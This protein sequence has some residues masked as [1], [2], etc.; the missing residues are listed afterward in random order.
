M[1]IVF[2]VSYYY[3]NY[4]AVGKCVGNV[5]DELSK[6]HRVTVIC[7]KDSYDQLDEE[8]INNQKIIRFITLDRK[9]RAKLNKKI[10]AS[11]GIK[12]KIYK[13]ILYFYKFSQAAKI[14]LSKVTI[15]QDLVDEYFE[16]L[17]Y[18]EE[19][20][21]VIIPAV[22][23]F[24]SLLAAV[25]FSKNIS[26]TVKV[27]PYL[28][29]Q[30]ALNKSL[31][32]FQLNMKLKLKNHLELERKALNFS[33]TV[34]I[35]PQ[36]ED[37]YRSV[38]QDHRKKILVLEH[39]LL[40]N[41]SGNLQ[42]DSEIIRFVYAG[43]F[44]KKIRNPEYFLTVFDNLL[45][46]IR[47]KLDLYTFGNCEGIIDKFSKKNNFII[48]HGK[49]KTDKVYR[50]LEKSNFLVAVGNSISN[51]VPSKIIE[52]LSFGKPIIYLYTNNKDPGLKYLKKFPLS[53]CLKQDEKFLSENILKIKDF[54][55]N[56]YGSKVD[57]KEVE[58]MFIEASPK[59]TVNM[60]MKLIK[61]GGNN[62]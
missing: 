58:R 32:R 19:E 36:L 16:A 17:D 29:D 59:Y 43:S 37:H 60:I 28:F 31:H 33:E 48:S 56:K 53:L 52:Y 21:D 54:C 10:K 3:P 55:R 23:P 14:I 38:I 47:G 41:K 24:E 15:K 7:E 39:P 2:L 13:T 6:I 27:I 11:K 25:R 30:F 8:I 45:T 44:Y 46:E 20:I 34:I 50:A 35:M 61:N 22:M 57:F 12:R 62:N 26:S 5:A 51:Q 1:H 9:I 42:D 18:I 4:S 49:Y 40:I